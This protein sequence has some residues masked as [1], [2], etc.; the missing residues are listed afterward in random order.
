MS[1][2]YYI[3][4]I[5]SYL[6]QALYRQLY[7]PEEESEDVIIATKTDPLNTEKLPGT[8]KILKVTLKKSNIILINPRDPSLSCSGNI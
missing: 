3:N 6:G 7:K 4:N 8:K 1:K 2:R 5:D